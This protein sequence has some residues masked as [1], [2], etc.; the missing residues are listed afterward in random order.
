M[1]TQ[2]GIVINDVAMNEVIIPMIKSFITALESNRSKAEIKEQ[3]NELL[4]S[5]QAAS[6]KMAM[7]KIAQSQA[8]H[9]ASHEN[10]TSHLHVV[11]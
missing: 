1:S 8:S 10:K 2:E 9:S 5:A 6:D 4:A 3:V 7:D 11:V